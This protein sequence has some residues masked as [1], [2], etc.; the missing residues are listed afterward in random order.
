MDPVQ[1]GRFISEERKA[2]SLTQKELAERLGVSDKAVSKW[3]RGICLPDVAKFD[4]IAEALE[5]TELEVLRARRIPEPEA[6]PPPEKLLTC[7][8]VGY[9]L[10]G[11]LGVA[12][13][14]FIGNMLEIWG[15]LYIYALFNLGQIVLSALFGVWYAWKQGPVRRLSL[16]SVY[17]GIL[18]ML[19]LIG[20]VLFELDHFLSWRLAEL[21]LRLFIPADYSGEVSYQ[22]RRALL[23]GPELWPPRFLIAKF[24]CYEILDWFAPV[25]LY[26]EFAGFLLIRLFRALVSARKQKRK[27][28][29]ENQE[30]V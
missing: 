6:P 24:V 27:G 3:E 18:S 2:K 9:L 5:I 23:N 15:I 20:L 11:W 28:R 17:L 8:N 29:P 21:F 10:L 1:F 13:I 25:S 19:A 30:T 14:C 12:A 4:D 26:L 16:H 7:R 22:A